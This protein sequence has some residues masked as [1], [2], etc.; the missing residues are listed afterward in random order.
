MVS[1]FGMGGIPLQ[2]PFLDEAVKMIQHALDVGVNFIDTSIGYG[3]SEIRIGQAIKDRRD[4]VILATKGS[5]RDGG[6]ASR[7]IDDSLKQLQTNHIDL[8]QFHNPHDPS[9]LKQLL[10]PGGAYE[11]AVEAKERGKI[12]HIGL[13][14]HNIEVALQAVESGLFETV[15]YPFDFVAHEAAEKLVPLC[16]EKNVGFIAMKPFAGG[17]IRDASLAI[18]YLLQY[19]R[20]LPIPGIERVEE[21]DEIAGVIEGSWKIR[22]EERR[23]MDKIRDELGKKFCRQCMY[24][25]PCPNGVEI[26]LLIYMRNLHRLWPRERFVKGWFADAAE[27]AKKCVGCGACEPKCPYGLPIR[28]IIAD[29]Y[30][31]F[32]RVKSGEIQ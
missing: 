19:D 25:M 13:S 6:L 2:R 21:I 15:M 14:T 4:E 7:N 27:T 3:D 12:L 31:F 18:K 17:N 28:E 29:N 5:W 22:P 23:R 8:W 9:N 20:V 30:A 32:Q 11:A 24:C 1:R 16:R 26:W 10:A